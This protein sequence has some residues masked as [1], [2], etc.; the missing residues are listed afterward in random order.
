MKKTTVLSPNIFF[1][2]ENVMSMIDIMNCLETEN[3]YVHQVFDNLGVK[4]KVLFESLGLP[5]ARWVLP[6]SQSSNMVV[7]YLHMWLCI[8]NIIT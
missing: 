7:F 8:Y 4:A 1:F 3:T 2:T 5:L 6:S